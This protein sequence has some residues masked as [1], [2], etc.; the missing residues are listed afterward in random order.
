MVCFN[1]IIVTSV[2]F[3]ITLNVL[4]TR[5]KTRARL[6]SQSAARVHARAVDSLLLRLVTELR[7]AVA[8][9]FINELLPH[10]SDC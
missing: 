1:I 5:V 8:L 9:I 6:E 4:V 3:C 7:V 2:L 10:L